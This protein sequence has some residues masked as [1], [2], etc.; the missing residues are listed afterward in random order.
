MIV[1]TALEV[2]LTVTNEVITI[3]P[4]DEDVDGEEVSVPV[5]VRVG[6]TVDNDVPV[7]V[8]VLED[9]EEVGVEVGVEEVVVVTVVVVVVVV[10]VVKEVLVDVLVAVGVVLVGEEFVVV[11]VVA[12]VLD[13]EEGS[14]GSLDVVPV[15]VGLA[16]L[17]LECAGEEVTE[18][19]KDEGV[20]VNDGDVFPESEDALGEG[21]E[22]LEP[23]PDA[24]TEF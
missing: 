23:E 8:V 15:T 20:D 19:W 10:V 17:R 21:L 22:T 16:A 14:D 24:E 5:N 3:D 9:V 12:G 2:P 13:V 18:V 7:A 6:E 1:R 4:P 11:E